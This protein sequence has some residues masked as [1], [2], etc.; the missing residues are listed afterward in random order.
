MRNSFFIFVKVSTWIAF[1]VIVALFAGKALDKHFGTRPWLF[2]ACM[3]LGFVISIV[4]IY[5]TS[6]REMKKLK[7]KNGDSN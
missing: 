5:K 4:G 2:I 6:I 3:G 1:P 7:E